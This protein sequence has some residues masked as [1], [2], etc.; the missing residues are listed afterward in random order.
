[1]SADI[2]RASEFLDKW[3]NVS[4]DITP[5]IEMYHNFTRRPGEWRE[6]FTRHNDRIIFGTDNHPP[7]DMKNTEQLDICVGNIA[8]IRD[9]LETDKE[10]LSGRGLKL[11]SDTLEKIYC[12]N[13][14]KR[15][16]MPRQS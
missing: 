11:G 7:G 3:R 12:G 10:M 9:F 5:G 15:I 13:F 14:M 4:L 16:F 2:A 1:M 6:F 8:M